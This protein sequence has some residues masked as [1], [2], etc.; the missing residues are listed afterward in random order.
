MPDTATSA[1]LL[2]EQVG[3]GM[4]GTMYNGGCLD[5][6]GTD[7]YVELATTYIPG[8]GSWALSMWVNGDAWSSFTLVSNTSGGPVASS[9]YISTSGKLSFRN[10]DGAWQ[11]HYANTTLSL[12]T[13]YFCTWVNYAGSSSTNGTMKMFVNGVA[14]SSEVNSYTTNGGR[15]NTIGRDSAD[16]FDGKIADVRFYNV[17]LSDANVKELYDDSRVI[18]PNGVSQTNLKRWWPM[19][20]GAGTIAYDGSGYG[21]IGTL[22]NMDPATDWTREGGA[23]ALIT[24]FNRP[25]LFKE[26]DSIHVD[27]TNT[28]SLDDITLSA[29]VCPTAHNSYN[30]IIRLG[31]A[32]FL[33][34]STGTRLRLV[35]GWATSPGSY[36][37]TFSLNTWYHVAATR[38]RSGIRSFMLM[39]LQ[40]I[41][42]VP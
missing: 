19:I 8:N 20:D 31:G 14:D 1:T 4:D 15:L 23:P 21:R 6:D 33:L 35:D 3:S 9:Y 38:V 2:Y 36:P 16:Y 7:D 40:F 22:T 18:I 29:W 26:S 25:L 39:G 10:Y 32:F 34:D 41:L 17:A 12:S 42:S 13:W 28:Q 11:Q 37:Y 27:W 5:F 24:G 30:P